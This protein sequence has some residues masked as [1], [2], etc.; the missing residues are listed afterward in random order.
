M[1]KNLKIILIVIALVVLFGVIIIWSIPKKNVDYVVIKDG[2]SSY[3]S[4][5]I[6][7]YAEYMEFVNYIDSQNKSYG[8]VYNFNS[9]KYN[10]KYFNNKSLAIIN[11]ITGS[12]MNELNNIDIS[13]VGNLL[14]CK[15]DINYA[16]G[17]G[18]GTTDIRG[19]LLLIE[20]DKS[21]TDF[22]IEG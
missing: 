21:V 6:S 22:K 12:G 20:I 1:N 4:K 19:K 15:V 13:V 17:I 16:S 3:K 8:K 7:T 10:E 14:I 9:N 5:I 11:I 18:I 2:Y